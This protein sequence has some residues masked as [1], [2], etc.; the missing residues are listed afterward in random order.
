LALLARE[1][2]LVIE[3]SLTP[4]ALSLSTALPATAR[5]TVIF[6]ASPRT[7]SSFM[8]I[9]TTGPGVLGGLRDEL[10]A[11]DDNRGAV[12]EGGNERDQIEPG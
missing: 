8:I 9:R 10:D 1:A 7:E 11:L 6:S 3:A 12:A 2:I 5:R 4:A